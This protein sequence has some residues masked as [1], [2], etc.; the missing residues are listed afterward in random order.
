MADGIKKINPAKCSIC[1]SPVEDKYR[2]FCSKRCANLDLGKWLSGGYAISGN[3][4]DDEDGALPQ[5]DGVQFDLDD[6]EPT[7]H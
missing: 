3:E 6:E 2:P 7:R 4:D 5:H 1:A